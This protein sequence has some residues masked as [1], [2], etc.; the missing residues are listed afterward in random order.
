[1]KRV[2]MIIVAMGMA[3]GAMAQTVT[4]GSLRPL[5]GVRAM[6]VKLD[7]S[8]TRVEG[9]R[10]NDYLQDL[11]YAHGGN[12]RADFDRDK[13]EMLSEFMEEFNDAGAPLILTISRDV[14]MHM[15]VVV[16][17]VNRKGNAVRCEYV[18]RKR[19]GEKVAV[20]EMVSKDGRIGS[21]TNLMG[22]AFEKAGEDLG[23]FVRRAMKKERKAAV[24]ECK[25][26]PWTCMDSPSVQ[27]NSVKVSKQ[28]DDS[29]VI[30]ITQ[31]GRV[32]FDNCAKWIADVVE[33]KCKTV[34]KRIKREAK[35]ARKRMDASL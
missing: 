21:F 3:M 26:K 35:K 2:K 4:Q 14:P 9:L 10:L 18:I 20:V 1:M 5:L 30:R 7:F 16:K 13:R 6:G 32:E 23:R 25:E 34:E 28:C 12:H 33:C 8:D 11:Y 19:N 17:E 29:H 27:G 24:K 22:D 15:T 31:N